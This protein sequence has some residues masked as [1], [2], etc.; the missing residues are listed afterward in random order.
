MII[1]L[2][3]LFTIKLN[4]HLTVLKVYAEAINCVF[5]HLFIVSAALRRQHFRILSSLN[6]TNL[7]INTKMVGTQ[8]L[9]TLI[10]KDHPGDW[11]PW[12]S[13]SGLQPLR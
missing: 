4:I 3:H 9:Y 6:F 5:S 8:G 12:E 2:V 11:R 7:F 10:E 13:S 1:T